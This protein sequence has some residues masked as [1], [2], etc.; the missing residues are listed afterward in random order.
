M[1]K[2]FYLSTI[3]PEDDLHRVRTSPSANTKSKYILSALS[4]LEIELEVI[5]PVEIKSERWS[6]YKQHIYKYKDVN[7]KCLSSFGGSKSFCQ[8]IISRL[9]LY[10]KLLYIFIFVINKRD[11]VLVYHSEK[12]MFFLR[13]IHFFTRTKINF[14][15]EELYGA[16][17][18]NKKR[19]N[20]ESQYLNKIGSGYICVNNLIAT[21]CNINSSKKKVICYGSYQSKSTEEKIKNNSDE[22]IKITYAGLIDENFPDAFNAVDLAKYLSSNYIITVIG[23]GNLQ[24]I[25][26]L[27]EKIENINN[28]KKDQA[29]VRYDGMLS[30]NELDGYL[31]TVSIGLCTREFE[32]EFADFTFPSKISV[33]LNSGII[34]ICTPIRSIKVSELSEYILFSETNRPQDIALSI[35]MQKELKKYNA[36][37]FHEKFVKDLSKLIYNEH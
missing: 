24:S 10:I 3:I 6:Y 30:G 5:S 16:I 13:L 36:S 34:P 37:Y 8:K 22:K 12:M 4:E 17:H 1:K 7:I 32:D 23:Y 11:F 21:R 26:K 33:Y 35:R 28:Y 19:C 20:V 25:D 31:K 9:W 29:Y 2:V 15:I 27:K 14:E 18:K